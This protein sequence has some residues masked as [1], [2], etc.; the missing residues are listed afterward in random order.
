MMPIWLK[1][2]YSKRITD[3]KNSVEIK[4]TDSS[5]NWSLYYTYTNSEKIKYQPKIIIIYVEKKDYLVFW[6]LRSFSI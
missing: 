1:T 3:Y 4:T 6:G 2:E 5:Y